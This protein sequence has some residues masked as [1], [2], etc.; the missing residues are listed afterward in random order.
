MDGSLTHAGPTG[1][2]D[3]YSNLPAAKEKDSHPSGVAVCFWSCWADS[4][5]WLNLLGRVF[6]IDFVLYRHV[7]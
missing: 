7:S 3:P 4:K 1:A 6:V 5:W 2:C